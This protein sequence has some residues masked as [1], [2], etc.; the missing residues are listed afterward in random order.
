MVRDVLVED[1]I[2]QYLAH[3]CNHRWRV[4]I[5]VG[6]Y[7]IPT[8]QNLRCEYI[9]LFFYWSAARVGR[10]QVQYCTGFDTTHRSPASSH[11]HIAI[12]I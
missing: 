2:V 5:M 1:C 3:R 7:V 4:G 8:F 12:A 9:I 11:T 10:A 6:I